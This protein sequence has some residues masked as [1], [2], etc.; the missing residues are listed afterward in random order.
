VPVV[1]V[2]VIPLPIIATP[3]VAIPAGLI[4]CLGGGEGRHGHTKGSRL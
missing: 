4:F 1:A 3:V 2:C